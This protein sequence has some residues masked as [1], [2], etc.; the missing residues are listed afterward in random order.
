MSQQQHPRLRAVDFPMFTS[1]V[2]STSR[3]TKTGYLSY[4]RAKVETDLQVTERS[5]DDAY[6]QSATVRFQP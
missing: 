2:E 1:Y 4:A 6:G 5:A 3:D